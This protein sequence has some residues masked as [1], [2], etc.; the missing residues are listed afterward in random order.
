MKIGRE[1]IVR[2]TVFASLIMGKPKPLFPSG[3][4]EKS[5]CHG[6]RIHREK[7]TDVTE[8]LL[9][10]AFLNWVHSFS[11]NTVPGLN[12]RKIVK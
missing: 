9:E 10:P 7:A 1:V 5:S 6:N 8:R 12:P 4:W 11:V 2:D 3:N